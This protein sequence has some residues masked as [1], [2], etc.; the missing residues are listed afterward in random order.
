[1]AAGLQLKNYLTSKTPEVK[2]QYQLRWLSIDMAVR[3]EI[4]SIVSVR[5]G[6]VPAWWVWFRTSM[7]GWVPYQ[8]GGLGS[9]PAWW[10]WFRTSMVGWVPYQHG[11][12]G[13]IPAR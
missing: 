13:S 9:I 8:H 7:V 12:L 1:M 3:A 5:F 10:V 11:G 4:K 6:F 2:L